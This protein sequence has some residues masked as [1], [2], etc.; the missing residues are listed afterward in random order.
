MGKQQPNVF[1]AGEEIKRE[2]AVGILGAEVK[3]IW[4]A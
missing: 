3:G 2:S 4:G 1:S